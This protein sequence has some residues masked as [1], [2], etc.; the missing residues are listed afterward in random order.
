MK[1]QNNG[2]HLFNFF[3]GEERAVKG[4]VQKTKGKLQNAYRTAVEERVSSEGAK[5]GKPL[6]QS[7]HA[8]ET[9]EKEI[10]RSPL[11]KKISRFA[12]NNIG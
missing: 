9:Q 4:L 7:F 12:L 11:L 2:Q 5:V 6:E 1:V 10:R 3:V 8:T